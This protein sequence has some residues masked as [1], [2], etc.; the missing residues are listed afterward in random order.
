[1][2]NF[3]ALLLLIC[4]AAC[5]NNSPAAKDAPAKDT[6][7][8]VT[9][10][11]SVAS[12]IHR[13]T[14]TTLENRI[15]DALLKLSFVKKANTYIDSFSNHRHGI[16]FMLDSLGKGENEIYVQAGYNGEERFETYYQFYV[17]PKTLEIKVYDVVDDKKLSVKEYLK[18]IH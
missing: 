2:R 8:V 17:N 15:T 11:D 3:F 10:N 7:A 18:T 4:F 1:M 5:N 13:F 16:A 9:K 6:L 12:Y 14:D